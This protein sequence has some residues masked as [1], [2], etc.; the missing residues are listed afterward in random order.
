MS[1]DLHDALGYQLSLTTRHMAQGFEDA[2]K[3]LGLTRITWCVLLAVEVE[4]LRHPSDIADFIGI[5]RTATSR[6]LRLLD[7]KDL[8]CRAGGKADRRTTSVHLT[9]QGKT[10]L[11]RAT[12]MAKTNRDIFQNRLSPSEQTDLRQLLAKLRSG[13]APPLQRL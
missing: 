12:K 1:Y 8:I 4:N 11:S 13:D 10:Q 7:A 9:D 5:D 2:L 3:T 6:A